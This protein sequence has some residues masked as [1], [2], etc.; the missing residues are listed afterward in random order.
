MVCYRPA[1][2]PCSEPFLLTW[3]ELLPYPRLIIDKELAGPNSSDV[4][5]ATLWIYGPAASEFTLDGT[6]DR[7]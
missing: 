7:K 1:K 3:I 4:S 5:A 2:I 6:P